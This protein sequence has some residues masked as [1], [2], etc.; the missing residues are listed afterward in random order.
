MKDAGADDDQRPV[1]LAVALVAL[2]TLFTMGWVSIVL[3]ATMGISY[4]IWVSR[5]AWPDPEPIIWPYAFS[6]AVLG[7]HVF[8]EYSSGFYKSFPAVFGAAPWSAQRFLAFNFLW[9]IIFL[10]G[11][12]PLAQGQRFGYL[13]AVFLALGGGIGNGLGHLA[14][15]AQRGGYFPGAYTGA[16]AL[17]AG[18]ALAYR[19]FRRS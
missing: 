16:V 10:V 18:A 13:V 9:L 14:L 6:F 17:I 5:K 7:A 2:L 4:L 1:A 3:V 8:E 11:G 19:L 12:F 15:S